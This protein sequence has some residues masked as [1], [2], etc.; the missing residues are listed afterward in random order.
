[1][2][3]FKLVW[4]QFVK[5]DNDASPVVEIGRDWKGFGE[6]CRKEEP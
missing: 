4:T 6:Q 5:E 1:V 2:T 3:P